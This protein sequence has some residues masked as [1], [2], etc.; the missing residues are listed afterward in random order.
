MEI[1][2]DHFV[3]APEKGSKGIRVVVTGDRGE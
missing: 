3:A 1:K 2:R